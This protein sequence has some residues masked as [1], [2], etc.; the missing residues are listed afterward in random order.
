MQPPAK[1][2][3]VRLAETERQPHGKLS[4]RQHLTGDD[5]LPLLTGVQTSLPGYQTKLHS[6]PYVECLFVLEGTMEVW[7][8]GEEA[9]PSRL[10]PGDMIA[11]PADIPHVFRNPGDTTLRHLGIHASPTRIVKNVGED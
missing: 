8:Q 4:F 6:H 1:A 2:T 11:L 10:G 9:T 3:I 5:G 7:L